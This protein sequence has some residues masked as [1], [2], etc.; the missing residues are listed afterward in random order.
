MEGGRK[1]DLRVVKTREAIQTAFERLLETTEFGEITISTIAREARVSRKTFYAHYSSTADLLADMEYIP[2]CIRL[3]DMYRKVFEALLWCN[4]PQNDW[5]MHGK[6]LQTKEYYKAILDTREAVL[7]ACSNIAARNNKNNRQY[8]LAKTAYFF[9][10]PGGPDIPAQMQ[11][12]GEE[13]RKFR[14]EQ[15]TYIYSYDPMDESKS[16]QIKAYVIKN[17]I[18]G[19]PLFNWVRNLE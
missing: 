3:K 10:A 6:I 15:Q 18:P 13:W 12:F 9:F 14:L 7:R 8:F 16:E 1:E 11:A 17:G 4:L 2:L 19:D 5:M